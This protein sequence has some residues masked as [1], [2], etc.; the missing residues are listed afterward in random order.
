MGSSKPKRKV[1]NRRGQRRLTI[2]EDLQKKVRDRMDGKE[3]TIIESADGVKMSEV[4]KAFIQP[5]MDFAD[6]EESFKKLVTI[7]VVAWNISL[8]PRSEQVKS[9]NDLLKSLPPDVRADTKSI[10]REL[11]RRKK[12][13]FAEFRRMIIEFEVVDTKNGFHLTVISTPENV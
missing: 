13:Y 11:M 7:A 12:K 4:L 2:G 8:L 9:V 1:R 6:T 5:Y 3:V 10:L